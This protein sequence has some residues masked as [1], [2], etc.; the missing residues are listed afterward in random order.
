M[1]RLG[2]WMAFDVIA[3]CVRENRKRSIPSIV[4]RCTAH[5][6]RGQRS[7]VR[8]NKKLGTSTWRFGRMV[9]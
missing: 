5:C 6:A 2:V 9:M 1:P 4:I 7:I 8:R 3:A